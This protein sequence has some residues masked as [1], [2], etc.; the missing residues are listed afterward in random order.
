MSNLAFEFRKGLLG[1]YRCAYMTQWWVGIIIRPEPSGSV[2]RDRHS[3][4]IS[5]LAR[6]L[7]LCGQNLSIDNYLTVERAISGLIDVFT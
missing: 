1:V 4:T 6:T 5:L 3:N 7:T 2:R